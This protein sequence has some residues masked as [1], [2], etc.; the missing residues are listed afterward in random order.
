MK[1]LIPIVAISEISF[2]KKNSTSWL[3]YQLKEMTNSNVL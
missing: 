1:L 3:F 2:L